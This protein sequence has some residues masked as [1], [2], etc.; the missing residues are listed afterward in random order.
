MGLSANTVFLCSLLKKSGPKGWGAIFSGPESR[1]DC[2]CSGQH[3]T[4]S[5]FQSLL[6]LA[7][8]VKDAIVRKAGRLGVL[9]VA[10]VS[11]AHVHPANAVDVFGMT[12]FGES[13][14]VPAGALSYRVSLNIDAPGNDSLTKLIADVS[15]L[16]LEQKRGA[17]DAYT[18][19]ARARGD[20]AQIQAALYSEGYYAGD[21]D[22]RV[23]GNKLEGLDPEGLSADAAG[24]EVGINITAGKQF[25]FGDIALI[26]QS[27]SGQAPGIAAA[28]LGLVRGAPAKSDLIVAASEKLVES[29]RAA[30][31]PLARITNKDVAAD[32]ARNSVD[33]RI[34]V[35][36]GPPAVYGW[37]G[38]SG[39]ST[40]D[41]GTVLAQS[42]LEPG[43][44]F[45]TADL[46]R[47]RDRLVKMPSVE[48]VR[49]VEGDAVDASGGLP[50]NLEIIE[51]KPRYF[52]A[53]A[54]VSTTD[55][56]EVE[57]YWGHRNFFGEGEHLRLEGGLSRIGDDISHLEFDAAAIYTKPGILDV[58]TNLFSEF[59]LARE[60][61]DTYESLDA[62]FKVGLARVFSP[63]L[64]GSTA[65]ATKF[66]RVEDAF[67]ERDF[68]L[69]SLPTELVYDTRDN[70]LEPTGGVSVIAALSPTVEAIGGAAFN[71]SE[72][73]AA[74]YRALD[75]DGRVVLAA[76][77][78][79]GSIAGAS[80]ADVPAS[81]RF[82][83]GGGG[84][85]RGYD[86]RSLGP[87]IGGEVV[88]G[89]GYV[90]GSAELRLRVTE[91]FG[92]V[93]F[94]DVATVT[95]DAWPSFSGDVFV[96]AGIGLRYYT[97]LG[98]LRVDV[99]TPLTHR[100]GQPS[101]AVYIGLGQ[102]F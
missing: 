97:V 98:P 16:M 101:A 63:S 62:S 28:D 2:L 78:G 93:P 83:A 39:A 79:A 13:T 3:G 94:I 52:G 48:S 37:V 67:G 20:V 24:I 86:Y 44:T 7:T 40:L 92:V 54:S 95:E 82:F 4:A 81:T 46:K 80:L 68:L 72:F 1:P 56:A 47:A 65:L 77:I 100:D 87:K 43:Q 12:L 36:P 6:R 75:A 29:W 69:V 32:H 51:R 66:S 31:Y 42:K 55:G 89:L 30:G 85:V 5:S 35:D 26:A 14:S 17:N 59:R 18:L 15:R 91:M 99:A 61:P 60:R 53:T 76:R 49:I 25:V 96:G 9:A 41:H 10:I 57:A 38:V 88:G 64:S 70:P 22:I 74:A 45:R 27:H 11:V 19:V 73:Q 34:E 50:V 21:I 102:A 23:A 90:G 58:D 8:T 33:L 71:K 84:S